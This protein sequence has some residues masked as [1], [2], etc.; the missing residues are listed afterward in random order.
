MVAEKQQAAKKSPRAMSRRVWGN[1]DKCD[2]E[3]R[4]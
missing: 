3:Q 1:S 2:I 4:L